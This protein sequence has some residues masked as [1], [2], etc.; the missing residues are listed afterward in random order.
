MKTKKG[1]TLIELLV[2]I[3]IIGIIA[4]IATISLYNARAKARDAKRIA[5][6][7]QIQT[8]LELFYNDEDRYPTAEE[9]AA[10]SITSNTGDGTV[11]YMLNIPEAPSPSDGSCSTITNAFTYTVDD[12]GGSYYIAY[13]L[14]GKTGDLT[15]GE[16]CATPDGMVNSSCGAISRNNERL[17]DAQSIIDAMNT[18]YDANGYY[19]INNNPGESYRSGYKG[20]SYDDVNGYRYGNCSGV[21]AYQPA[22][23]ENVPWIYWDTPCPDTNDWCIKLDAEIQTEE[24]YST[25]CDSGTVY[26]RN[27]PLNNYNPGVLNIGSRPYKFFVENTDT[28]KYFRISYRLE[29]TTGAHNLDSA[30]FRGGVQVVPNSEETIDNWAE[31]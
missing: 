3:A 5:N 30:H 14:G 22:P 8:A 11:T 15:S 18:M 19:L 17:A 13:C 4:T 21:L 24:S 31:L 1:F 7:K 25:N 9:W 29:G 2:V 28:Y 20:Y 10:G 26:L 23:L 27:I 16:K 6:I 12:D